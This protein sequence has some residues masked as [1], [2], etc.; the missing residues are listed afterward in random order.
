RGFVF[1]SLDGIGVAF[2][3]LIAF[4]GVT[5]FATFLVAAA[6][7]AAAAAAAA[8]AALTV[9]FAFLA[10]LRTRGALVGI[11]FFGFFFL[12]GEVL[13]LILLDR[14]DG[15]EA[16]ARDRRRTAHFDRHARALGLAVGQD[17]DRDAVKLLDLAQ[18]AAL[19]VEEV[20]GCLLAGAQGDLAALAACGFLFDQA[21]RAEARRARG[22]DKAGAFAMRA[23]ARRGFEHAGAQAL[24]AHLH[25]AEARDAADLDARTV[26][27]QRLLHRALDL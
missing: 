11:V 17:F 26:V 2:A 18:F 21:Q 19:F 16:A 9:A 14:R 1:A 23:G 27:L 15:G 22:A 8:L 3:F 25:Q 13:V 5:G 10:A 4:G 12:F 24:A 7:T 6:A 20:E